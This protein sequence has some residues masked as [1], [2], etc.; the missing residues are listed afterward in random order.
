M[1]KNEVLEPLEVRLT[2]KEH[3]PITEGLPTISNKPRTNHLYLVKLYL[4]LNQCIR[5][6]KIPVMAAWPDS[7]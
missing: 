7:Y 3:P 6:K 2:A 4:F 5:V 1:L